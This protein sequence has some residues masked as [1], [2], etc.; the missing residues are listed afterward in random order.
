[1]KFRLFIFKDPDAKDRGYSLKGIKVPLTFAFCPEKPK[2]D[3][4]SY[5]GGELSGLHK[6]YWVVPAKLLI[7]ARPYLSMFLRSKKELAIPRDWC[8]VTVSPI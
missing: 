5:N 4:K 7:D 6:E 8:E 3:W 1:M 2:P